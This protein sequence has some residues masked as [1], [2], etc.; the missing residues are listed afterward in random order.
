MTSSSSL[1]MRLSRTG[2]IEKKGGIIKMTPTEAR[3]DALFE[4]LVPGEG[5]AET[6]AGEIVRAVERIAYRYDNDGDRI[7]IGYGREICNPA[8]RYLS[9]KCGHEVKE[10][11]NDIWGE[12][13]KRAYNEGLKKLMQAVLDFLDVHPGLRET[14]NVEDMWDYQDQDEDVEEREEDW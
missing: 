7:G 4:E 1:G 2:R 12:T 3:L 11:I 14:K 9:E 6:V 13:D 5:K 10:A 8:A